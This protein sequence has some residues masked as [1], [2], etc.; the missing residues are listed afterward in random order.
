M[1]LQQLN[2]GVGQ[3]PVSPIVTTMKKMNEQ[4]LKFLRDSDAQLGFR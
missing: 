1:K 2:S 3:N 4:T